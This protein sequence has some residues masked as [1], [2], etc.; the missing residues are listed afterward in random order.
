MPTGSSR[1]LAVDAELDGKA[2]LAQLLDER[3]HVAEPGLGCE[4][5]V[6]VVAEHAEQAA[7]LGQRAAPGLLDRLQHLARRG[8]R[9]AEHAPLGARLHDDHRDVVG[10]HVVQLTRDPRPFLDDRLTGGHVALAL[11]DL[12]AALAVAD[13]AADEQHHHG[14]DD[15]IGTRVVQVALRPGARR[16]VD[17]HD[18]RQADRKA[19]R[20][21]PDRQRV[22]RAEDRRR[23]C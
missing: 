14:R 8:V 9:I 12:R 20:R 23:H 4:R 11:G 10:D 15:V 18:Q 2:G 7:H 6:R 1:A 19:A 17:R 5:L 3:R 22:Q 13:D 16:E 21:R